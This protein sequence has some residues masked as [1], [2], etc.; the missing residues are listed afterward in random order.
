M[1]ERLLPSDL[2]RVE[3][4]MPQPRMAAVNFFDNLAA[5]AIPYDLVMDSSR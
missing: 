3:N 2:P 1:A 5:E 4:L